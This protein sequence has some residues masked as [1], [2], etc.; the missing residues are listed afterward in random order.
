M[1]VALFLRAKGAVAGHAPGVLL[2]RLQM[3]VQLCLTVETQETCQTGEHVTDVVVV[4]E[5]IL[6]TPLIF[7]SAEAQVA[8]GF[9]IP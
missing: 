5:V 9:V 1:F 3:S 8:E 6:E 4:F 7:E 2:R